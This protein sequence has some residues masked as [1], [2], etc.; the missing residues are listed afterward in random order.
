MG[1]VGVGD[2]RGLRLG[3]RRFRACH[4]WLVVGRFVV[5]VGWYR[6]SGVGEAGAVGGWRLRCVAAVGGVGDGVGEGAAGGAVGDVEGEG[7]VGDALVD[8]G[9]LTV[10][11]KPRHSWWRYP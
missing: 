11:V 8:G 6:I 3:G 1:V 4:S 2:G 10:G 7:A 5:L 9:V